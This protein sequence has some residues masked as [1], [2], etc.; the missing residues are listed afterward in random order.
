[1]MLFDKHPSIIKWASESVSVPYRN[2]LTG[3]MTLYIPDLVLIY[4][5]KN[6]EQRAEMIEIKPEKES[7]LFEGK[8]S[9]ETRLVQAINAAKWQ[10]AA[11]WCSKNGM[12]FRVL[13]EREM[14]G[15]AKG[16]R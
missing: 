14:F 16:A 4:E 10:A 3:K 13:T 1:M 7:P 5:D 11:A 9:K 2:P 15:R 8:V 6:G 12:K